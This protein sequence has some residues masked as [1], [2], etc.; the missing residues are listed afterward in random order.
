MNKKLLLA[1]VS[2]AILC[3]ASCSNEKPSDNNG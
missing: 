2:T 1:L 3:L